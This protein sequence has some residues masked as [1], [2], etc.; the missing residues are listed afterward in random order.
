[1]PRHEIERKRIQINF[2]FLG[3]RANVQW[4][5]CGRVGKNCDS[6]QGVPDISRYL[7]PRRFDQ[8]G[9]VFSFFSRKDKKV[10]AL[11][12][13]EQLNTIGFSKNSVAQRW[14]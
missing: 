2:S 3:Y 7:S 5:H 11:R 10:L 6:T 14:K 9:I 4:S 12:S 8:Y 1:M 13:C